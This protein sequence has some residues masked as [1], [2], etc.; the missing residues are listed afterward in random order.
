MAIEVGQ[1]APDFTL[2]DTEKNVVKLS[3]LRGKN[4]L[5]LFFPL[6][7]TS[8]CT[9]E[10]CGIRDDI[11]RYNNSQ[12]AVFGISVDAYASLKK[13]KEEQGYNFPLLSDF[14]KEATIAYQCAYDAFAGWMKDV[15]KRS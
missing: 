8:I 11:A 5:L 2:H 15:S 10:L 9:K 4:V 13:F 1:Q 3:E 14:N 7:F 12:A 6:A